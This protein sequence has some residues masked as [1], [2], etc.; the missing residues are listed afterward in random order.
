MI[1]AAAWGQRN[2]QPL[3][4]TDR[5]LLEVRRHRVDVPV[6]QKDLC[7]SDRLESPVNERRQITAKF[8][9]QHPSK[10]DHDS[11]SPPSASSSSLLFSAFI[12]RA[13][14]C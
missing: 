2:E 11:R 7:R 12:R 13:V 14:R 4:S 8:H 6:V 5:A 3:D 9:F 10:I 1:K